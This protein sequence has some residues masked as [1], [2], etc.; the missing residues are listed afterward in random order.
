MGCDYYRIIDNGNVIAE[1]MTI[2]T[3]LIVLKALFAE[4]WQDPSCAFTVEKMEA[5]EADS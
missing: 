3:T 5:N 4:Y 1:H 2:G